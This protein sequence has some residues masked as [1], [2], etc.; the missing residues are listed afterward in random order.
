LQ[1]I[2]SWEHHRRMRK[3]PWLGSP[4]NNSFLLALLTECATLPLFS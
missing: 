3:A 1:I 2:N 4:P